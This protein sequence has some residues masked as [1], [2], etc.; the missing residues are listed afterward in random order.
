MPHIGDNT[1]K[2]MSVSK[3]KRNIS[4]E[5]QVNPN[6]KHTFQ[7][8]YFLVPLSNKYLVLLAGL[9]PDLQQHTK[10]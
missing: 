5:D 3:S 7:N 2:F 10:R 9:S 1:A 6:P 8:P 4:E